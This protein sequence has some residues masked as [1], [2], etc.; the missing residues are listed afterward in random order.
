MI[1]IGVLGSTKGTDL[2]PILDEIAKGK[3]KAKVSVVVSNIQ[4]AYILERANKNNVPS[5]FIS[6]KNSTREEFDN[7]ITKLFLKYDVELILLIGFMRILSPK[8]CLQWQDKVLNV[9]PS[10][11]PKY[12]GEMDIGVHE[13]VIKNKD[14]ETGCTI[15]FVTEDLDCGPILVQKKC[16]VNRFDDAKTLKEKVQK[17][18]GQAFLEAIKLFYY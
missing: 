9:H 1:K 14:K 12:S 6:H 2:Q 5:F 10:L 18:E 13:K 15:H 8:F 3:L 7:K 4:N 11:L 17:L 16:S